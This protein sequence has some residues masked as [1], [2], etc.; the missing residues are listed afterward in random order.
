MDFF[1]AV[2]SR[3]AANVV[4]DLLHERVGVEVV[5]RNAQ[6]VAFHGVVEGNVGRADIWLRNFHVVFFDHFHKDA[7]DFVVHANPGHV[8]AVFRLKF[9]GA[10]SER[11]E[12]FFFEGTRHDFHGKFFDFL[13]G[14]LFVI[15][16]ACKFG[17][18]VGVYHQTRF[19][20]ACQ[21]IFG[22]RTVVVRRKI[23]DFGYAE[24][25]QV[26]ADFFA[27]VLAE[28]RIKEYPVVFAQKAAGHSVDGVFPPHGHG[29]LG[30]CK[31]RQERPE[32]LYQKRRKYGPH[33]V[34]VF[35]KFAG[36]AASVNEFARGIVDAEQGQLVMVF[37]CGLVNQAQ[38]VQFAFTFGAESAPTVTARHEDEFAE[39]CL[40][41]LLLLAVKDILA[42]FFFQDVA[43]H[44]FFQELAERALRHVV[45]G[46][47]FLGKRKRLRGLQIALRKVAF[48]SLG[49]F[50]GNRLVNKGNLGP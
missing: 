24:A 10:F 43:G 25:E 31:K 13:A 1:D 23:P 8:V 30:V 40:V 5:R 22:P 42:A 34:R 27:G 14:N 45:A 16:R 26:A 21:A 12:F 2:E 32:V 47:K 6:Q 18:H 39:G 28:G 9:E 36:L 50:F 33:G 37:T 11:F 48:E 35:R 19:F 46:R 41:S 20:E 7:R 49:E 38:K 44:L 3:G 17:V 29:E 15:P 4:E